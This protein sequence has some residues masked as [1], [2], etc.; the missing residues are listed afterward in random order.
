[1]PR[2][3]IGRGKHFLRRALRNNVATMHAR[4]GANIPSANENSVS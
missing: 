1:L 3:R 2:H 4:T